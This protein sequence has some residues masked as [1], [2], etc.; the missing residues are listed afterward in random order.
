MYLCGMED[1][2]TV[3]DAKYAAFIRSDP[4]AEGRFIA[5]VRTTGIF[6]RPSCKA[7]KPLPANVEFFDSP[8]AALLAGYRPCKLCRPMEPFSEEMPG[9]VRTL[10]KEI[11]GDPGRRL[12]DI[13]LRR[14]GID[15]VFVRR[16]FKR[17]HGMTFQSYQRLRRLGR[18]FELMKTGEAV[19]AA[20]SSA[21]FDSLSAFG[22]SFRKAFGASPTKTA[23][24]RLLTVTRIDTPLGPLTA[25][26]VEQGLCFLDFADGE[27]LDAELKTLAVLLKAQILPGE[28]PWFKPLTVQLKEY[29]DGLR[30]GFELP[31]VTAGTAFQKRVWEG[32]QKIP[33]GETKSYREQAEALGAPK[34][35]RAVARANGQNRISILIPCHRVIGA[36]GSLTGYGGGLWRKRWLL[37]LEAG[38]LAAR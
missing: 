10:M 11:E 27:A 36:D 6:C 31:L 7:K 33:Y 19:A 26:A 24:S 28:S 15:P 8:K 9:M 13:S 20:A 14:Q 12:D 4:A 1:K 35:V 30:K 17:H 32:L 18:A 2:K 21:G 38:R 23:T 22:D 34:A 16:W 3:F 5:G 25:G 37:D 29:F